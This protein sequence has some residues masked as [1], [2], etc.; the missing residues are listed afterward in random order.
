[1]STEKNIYDDLFRIF[2]WFTGFFLAVIIFFGMYNLVYHYN[3]L[4][5]FNQFCY[6]FY[7]INGMLCGF[8]YDFFIRVYKSNYFMGDFLISFYLTILM[9]CL[10]IT[11]NNQ[12][13]K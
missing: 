9:L 7:M 2:T 12:E 8:V 4:D 6:L 3:I 13:K 5:G 10:M 11:H 1:M